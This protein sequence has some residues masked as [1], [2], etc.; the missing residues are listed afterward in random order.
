MARDFKVFDWLL[1]I[2]KIPLECMAMDGW[3]DDG[4]RARMRCLLAAFPREQLKRLPVLAESIRSDQVDSSWK[5]GETSGNW[6]MERF[7]W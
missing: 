4:Q 7:S 3:M 1:A 6:G 2:K 5:G